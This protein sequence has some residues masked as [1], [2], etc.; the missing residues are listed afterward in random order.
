V[1]LSLQKF[2]DSVQNPNTKKGY[3]YAR[4]T[5][6]ALR[7]EK[8]NFVI[9]DS[10]ILIDVESRLKK[11]PGKL[12]YARSTPPLYIDR[13]KPFVSAIIKSVENI[14][15]KSR[16]WNYSRKTGYNIVRRAVNVYPH[17]FRLNRIT[18]ILDGG[19]VTHAK[20]WTGLT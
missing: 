13:S 14:R 8:K 1:N 6:E 10:Y 20:T 7:L 5:R 15:E 4:R 9:E 12:A 19:T 18:R 17:Y 3:R 2:L 16:V 11:D